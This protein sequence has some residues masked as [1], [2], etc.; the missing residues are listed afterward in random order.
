[1]PTHAMN[2]C[3]NFHTNLS[4]TYGDFASGVNGRT[5]VRTDNPKALRSPR[6]I[7][8]RGIKQHLIK[9]KKTVRHTKYMK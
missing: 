3:A 7:I 9:T 6:T 1:M 4:A 8:D 2:V 5:D